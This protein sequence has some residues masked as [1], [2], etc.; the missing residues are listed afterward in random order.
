MVLLFTFTLGDIKHHS[1]YCHVNGMSFLRQR[2][3]KDWKQRLACNRYGTLIKEA[4]LLC[5]RGENLT[6]LP[7]NLRSSSSV[8]SR[9][10]LLEDLYINLTSW[11]IAVENTAS[12]SKLLAVAMI[13]WLF[14]RVWR[15][16][17]FRFRGPAP[18]FKLRLR[19]SECLKP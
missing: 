3:T 2:K 16:I 11:A 9:T 13:R 19:L 6:W 14:A 18:K 4:W 17:Y 1:F 12:S 5:N 7:S 10:G 8:K 15:G